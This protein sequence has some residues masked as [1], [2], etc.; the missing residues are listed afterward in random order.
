MAFR[1][2]DRAVGGGIEEDVPVVEGG[3]EQD[4]VGAK[5]PVA[6]HVTGHVPDPDHGQGVELDVEAQ[7][8]EVGAHGDPGAPGGDPVALVVVAVAPARREG[9]V[10]PEAV[11]GRDLVGGVGEGGGASVGGDDE[12]GVVT[13]AAAHPARCDHP[14][15]V[16]VVGDVEEPTDEG[17]VLPL[18]LGG[19]LGGIRRFPGQDEPALG[20]G[21]HDHG[22]LEHLRLDEVEHLVAD[23]VAP[24]GPPQAAPGDR[25][26]A[27]V[28]ALQAW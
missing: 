5:Q 7:L 15:A 6:E 21:G 22:V 25:A 8:P 18:G 11:A 28:D 14:V 20:A 9:V 12:V 2:A 3:H 4:A 10:E 16:E 13:V 19:P 27:Q 23:V 1:E 17:H 24:V 26:V